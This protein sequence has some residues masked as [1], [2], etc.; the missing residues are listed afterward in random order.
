M[1]RGHS[2]RA[3]L[4]LT[5]CGMAVYVAALGLYLSF[6]IGPAVASLQRDVRPTIRLSTWLTTRAGT[7]G[8]TLVDVERMV[9]EGREPSAAEIASVRRRMGRQGSRAEATPFA[10]VP[11][12]LREALA[13]ADDEAARLENRLLEV[14]ALVELRRLSEARARLDVARVLN[15]EVARLLGDA[16]RLGLEDLER[17]EAS[18]AHAVKETVMVTLLW[19]AAAILVGGTLLMILYR[20][21]DRPLRA[22]ERGLDAVAH[23]DLSV[24]LPEGRR[25]ELGRLTHQFNQTTAL[26]R[27]R[28]AEQGRFA[29]AGQLLADVAHEVNNPLMAIGA[30]TENRLADAALSS[31]VRAELEMVQKQSRRAARLVSGLLR[32]VRPAP[33]QNDAPFDAD[34]AVRNAIELVS[35]QFGVESVVLE[36]R[37]RADGFALGSPSKLEQVLVNLLGN[38]V[39]AMRRAEPPRLLLVESWR[40]ERAVHVAVTDSG[41][42]VPPELAHR[43]FR[44]FTTSKGKNGTGLGLYISRQLLRASGGEL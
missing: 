40:T 31:P 13:R 6:A 22:L 14:A 11:P 34:A 41:P 33:E 9:A 44:P 37:L 15:L 19:F 38:A 1:T 17:R 2:L 21:V 12:A 25:D 35:Y 27:R 4:R 24:E 30:L 8:E 23:G 3:L 29:A 16:Q 5:L 28:A 20:R 39:D 32:F 42:G 7:L 10:D 26:L 18:L 36:T 43:L